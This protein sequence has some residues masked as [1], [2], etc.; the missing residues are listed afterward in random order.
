MSSHWKKIVLFFALAFGFLSFSSSSKAE[1]NAQAQ[2][3]M[4]MMKTMKIDKAQVSKMID[5]M[6]AAGHF[7]KEEA[8]L[9][10]QQLMEMNDKELH[11][12]AQKAVSK[13]QDGSIE[14]ML[15]A[16]AVKNPS[17]AQMKEAQKKLQ[18]V[19]KDIQEK[20]GTFQ[21]EM[22]KKDGGTKGKSPASFDIKNFQ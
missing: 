9:A 15:P 6:V 11:G 14:N 17:E 2:M 10:K 19:Q 3:M 8:D 5:S 18:Q 20:M 7:K 22:I 12:L 16:S 1:G 21:K 13:V 4:Q